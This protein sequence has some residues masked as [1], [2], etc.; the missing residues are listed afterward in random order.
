LLLST[1]AQDAGP[2]SPFQAAAMGTPAFLT[3]TGIAEEFFE[4]EKAGCIVPVND[5]KIWIKKLNEI[6]NGKQIKIPENKQLTA[7]GD[8][9]KVSEYYYNIYKTITKT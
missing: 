1:S 3:A 9:N 4:A 6:L 2:A 5:Y 7:F 8:W